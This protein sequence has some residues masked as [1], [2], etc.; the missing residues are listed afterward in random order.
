MHPPRAHRPGFRVLQR[1]PGGC[2][3]GQRV[4]RQGLEPRTRGLRARNPASTC[5]Q[6]HPS[7]QVSTIHEC[8]QTALAERGLQP[9]LQ[10]AQ[11]CADPAA[12]SFE[13]MAR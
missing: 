5:V 1:Q 13:G 10:P 3:A 9:E 7:K 12:L 4:R 11:P 2:A 6:G 8:E